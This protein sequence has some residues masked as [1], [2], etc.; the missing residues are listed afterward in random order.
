MDFALQVKRNA[1]E[2]QD[3]FQDLLKWEKHIQ[4]VKVEEKGNNAPIRNA[5]PN[6][7]V[8]IEDAVDIQE[9]LVQ[10]EK[11]NVYFKRQDYTKA[12]YCYKQSIKFNP[13]LIA[14][15]LNRAMVVRS[16]ISAISS[17]RDTMKRRRIALLSLKGN[18]R[19]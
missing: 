2:Y 3:S 10:K 12:A 8:E 16:Y 13:T 6:A 11:G 15:M 7:S 5:E 9:A 1:Q 4:S 14:S 18:R 17:W 19:I